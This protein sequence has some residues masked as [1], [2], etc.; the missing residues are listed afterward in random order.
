MAWPQ[1]AQVGDLGMAHYERR[2]C[3]YVPVGVR[4]NR[5]ATSTQ[6]IP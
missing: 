3:P 6:R 5:R 1:F 2:E 4:L